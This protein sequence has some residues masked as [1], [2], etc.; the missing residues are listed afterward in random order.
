MLKL[1]IIA[2]LVI[3]PTQCLVRNFPNYFIRLL[4]GL[5]H[6]KKMNLKSL[7]HKR[8]QR[9]S[10]MKNN[11]KSSTPSIHQVCFQLA[12]HRKISFVS[13]FHRKIEKFL[14]FWSSKKIQC[15]CFCF[16][17]CFFSKEVFVTNS[18]SQIKNENNEKLTA[19]D[20]R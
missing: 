12:L 13:H 18:T 2:K 9:R 17:R 1:H 8:Q 5:A 19:K 16:T 6:K 14:R 15:N 20:P 11:W 10:E 4:Y 7:N 3:L